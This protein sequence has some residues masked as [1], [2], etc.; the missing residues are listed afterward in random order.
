MKRTFIIT[1]LVAFGSMLVTGTVLTKTKSGETA[2]KKEVKKTAAT[3]SATQTKTKSAGSAKSSSK[4]TS[5]KTS[6]KEP[7]KQPGSSTVTSSTPT[8]RIDVIQN[9]T[10]PEVGLSGSQTGEQINWQAITSG[11][12]FSSSLNFGLLSAIG[13]PAV[14]SSSSTNF[15]LNSGFVQSFGGCCANAGNADGDVLGKVNIAD[16]TYLIARIFAGGPAPPCCEEGSA[17][18]SDKVNIADVTYLIA[19]IFAGGPAPVCGP[20]GMGC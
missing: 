4:S 2:V 1:L 11:G 6:K 9:F 7:V 20:V 19:R 8:K 5:T 15:N 14:G 12:G 18:G 13:Q 10:D 16:I 17:D 3:K